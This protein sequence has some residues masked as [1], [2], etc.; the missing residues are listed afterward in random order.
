MINRDATALIQLVAGSGRRG[1]QRQ[2]MPCLVTPPPHPRQVDSLPLSPACIP[3]SSLCCLPFF[4]LSLPS[5]SAVCLLKPASFLQ[6]RLTFL[7][8]R[9]TRVTN[10]PASWPESRWKAELISPSFQRKRP[11]TASPLAFHISLSFPFLSFPSFNF[12]SLHFPFFPWQR[13]KQSG[14]SAGV[15][16]TP[17]RVQGTSYL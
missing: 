4:P 10:S 13:H 1:T 3:L 12:P 15:R 16:P 8:P 9:F 11:V 6:K 17:S 7:P 14:I 5:S 2:R